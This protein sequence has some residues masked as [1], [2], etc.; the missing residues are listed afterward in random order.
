MKGNCVFMIKTMVIKLMHKVLHLI[1]LLKCNE[2]KLTIKQ[3]K[4]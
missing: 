2:D 4:C 3:T 1:N